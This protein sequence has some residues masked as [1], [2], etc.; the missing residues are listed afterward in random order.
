MTFA[1]TPAASGQAAIVSSGAIANL[2]S[3]Q[4][5]NI[6]EG[7]LVTTTD[8]KRWQ[9]KGTGDKTLEASYILISD[10]TPEWTTIAGRP[11]IP[12]AAPAAGQIMAGNS[13]GTAFATVSVSGDATLASTGALTIAAAA[14]GTSKLGGDITTA[15]KALL[16]DADAAAQR[17]T[18]GLGNSSTLNTGTT[19]GTVA[20]GDHT[21]ADLHTRSHAITSTSDHT[22]GNWQVFY[23]NGSGQITELPLGTS[24]QVLQSNGAAAAP[25]FATPSSLTGT[26]SVDNAILRADGTGGAT[27]QSSSISISDLSVTN[28]TTVSIGPDRTAFNVSAAAGTVITAT[29]HNFVTN[30]AVS[31]RSLTG[32]SGLNVFTRYFVRSTVVAGT[33]FEVSTTIGGVAV[34]F[35]TPITA[36]TVISAASLVLTQ[37]S[38]YGLE[39]IATSA[40]DNTAVGGNRRG[41]GAV[42]LSMYRAAA[43][44]VASGDGAFVGP[45]YAGRASGG[46]SAAIACY[47][48]QATG[49]YSFA[50]GYAARSTQNSSM[51]MGFTAKAEANY[52]AVYAGSTNTA[53]VQ[54]AGILAGENALA[55]RRC[56]QAHASGQFSAQGDAQRARF[57]LRNKTTNATATELYLD[58]S[59]TRLTVPSGK[60]IGGT[61]QIAGATSGG[62]EAVFY[63][64][65]FCIRNRGGT[66]ALVGS[67]QT[68]GTDIEDAALSGANVTLTADDTNDSLK[69]E[70]TG[71]APLTGCTIDSSGVNDNKILKTAH[72]LTNGQDIVFTSL[73]GGAGLTAN[74][75]TYWVI[76]SNAN[77]FQVSTTRGGS[78]VNI[79]TDYT[80][81]TVARVIRWVANVD[82]TEIG[83]GT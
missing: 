4:Q 70:V 32:G 76:N 37:G 62:E 64:R 78:A 59:S 6:S 57:V 3:G 48:T 79:T 46:Y 52:A 63:I 66:T 68:V 8:G 2:T 40:P 73:T 43:A 75:V 22:A 25:S 26:G 7:S 58:G 30:Q 34:T 67:I 77:D 18:L 80:D 49:Q 71:I 72:G 5:A 11:S 10:E 23:S 65:Q 38:Q 55:N 50:A 21:H 44:D 54:S 39:S 35:S 69:V 74:T 81:A 12:T 82:C 47:D 31:F 36:G 16:D 9:Y 20:L 51:A 13:G 83:H 15:G 24:G 61:I 1:L 27:L 33:S 14:V 45:G 42:D 19:A 17:T 60:T 53:N 56:M 29:G 28:D 41:N